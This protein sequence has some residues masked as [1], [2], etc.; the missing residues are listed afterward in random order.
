MS[1]VDKTAIRD[2]KPGEYVAPAVLEL[3]TLHELTLDC[4]KT[5]GHS[6]GYTFQGQAI[7]C[8]GSR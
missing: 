1:E 7:V 5:F 6:D 8:R 2:A 3:G 4:D